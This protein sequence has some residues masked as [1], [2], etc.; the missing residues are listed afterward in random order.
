MSKPQ[1]PIGEFDLIDHFF[2]AK[3]KPNSG[4]FLGIGDD[5]AILNFSN[6]VN[7]GLAISTDML[8]EGRHFLKD[9]NPQLLG[10]KSLAVNLSDLAA[11]GAKPLGFTLALALPEVKPQWLSEFST[12]LLNLANQYD[13]TLI[14]GDTTAGPLT[15]SI[16]V[17][18]QIDRQK[19]LLRS[20]A[21]VGDDIWVS[22]EVGDARLALGA[23][24]QEWPLTQKTQNLVEKRMHAP[25][26]RIELGL[27]LGDIA[28]AAIDISDGLL[29]DLSHILRQSQVCAS[30]EMD[31][32]PVSDSLNNQT[33]ELRRLCALNG[34]DDYE[35]CFTAP[36]SSYD[37]IQSLSKK[38]HLKLTP[39][40]KIRPL[41]QNTES[42]IELID[43]NGKTLTT[44]LAKPYL[45]SFDH[46]K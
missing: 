5:C 30:I 2:K 35:I 34:G 8:V 44:E 6:N 42:L 14:G 18:G 20:N 7:Y 9:A 38:L 28:H 37:A 24:R 27:E 46:F 19:A 10:H 11:M 43:H 3:Q 29:G 1:E 41:T 12:G 22:H 17:F 21:K 23:I 39:I 31:S 45:K 4:V 40:G 26:P 16:T 36:P 13:C 32:V 15:I 25:T 33:P